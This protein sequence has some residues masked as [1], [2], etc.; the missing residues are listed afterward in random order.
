MQS[1]DGTGQVPRP[2]RK[3]VLLLALAA[4]F[5]AP[6]LAQTDAARI[7]ELERQLERSL[8]LIERLNA[9]VQQL[10]A[11]RAAVGTPSAGAVL[12]ERRSPPIAEAAAAA[13]ALP[14]TAP[15]PAAAG[16]VLHGFADVGFV[17]GSKSRPA[18]AQVGSLDLY[19]TPSF[20]ERGRG[21][22]E[23]VFEVGSDGALTADLERLQIGY[24]FSDA[25]TLWAGRFHTPF[26]TW[27][28][29]FHH[30][31]QIQTAIT[32]PRFL[33]FEDAGGVLPVHTVGAWGSGAV[34]LPAGRVSYDLYAGNAPSIAI[35]DAGRAGS[36]V[37]DV[38]MGGTR[39]HSAT[40]GGNLALAFGGALNGLTVGLH[41]LRSTVAD[42]LALPHRSRVAMAG[43][44]LTYLDDDWELLAELYAFRNRE[45]GAAPG[46]RSSRA[47]YLQLGR[48]LAAWT[49]FARIERAALDQ[50]DPY[51]AQQASGASYSRHVLGLRY[52]LTPT[53]ALKVEGNRSRF[54]DRGLS[55]YAELRS[56]LAVR[57]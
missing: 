17:G 45:L 47:H 38:G 50:A 25:L 30:G 43:A 35:D 27:N 6:A 31:Q 34:K 21:L 7:T 42:T 10:E 23:L 57:F 5:A 29:A 20:G 18:G 8:Q 11:D 12:P 13:A 14:A 52:E 48:A 56:Q 26:G 37:L 55:G 9:R 16:L 1:F 22:V 46:A 53:M 19:M 39:T 24:A 2:I 32:R 28:T 44:W 49:P 36:G 15:A 40:L 4:G 33:A 51:F 54:Q 41:A 3:C